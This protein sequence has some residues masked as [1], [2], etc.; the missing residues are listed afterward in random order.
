M[1]ERLR[2]RNSGFRS[3]P[4]VSLP[5]LL[6]F[7]R[8]AIFN[9]RHVTLQIAQVLLNLHHDRGDDR[10]RL[11]ELRLEPGD[12]TWILLVRRQLRLGL[13]GFFDAA[14]ERVLFLGVRN[15]VLL[16]PH[17]APGLDLELSCRGSVHFSLVQ[18]FLK[19]L[20]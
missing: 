13:L 15:V 19:F 3:L 7:S 14:L 17:N 16:G 9:R 11:S 2:L 12:S 18:V 20:L 10:D 6:H 1:D 4:L 8:L 5:D